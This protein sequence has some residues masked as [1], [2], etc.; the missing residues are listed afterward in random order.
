MRERE[1]N[2]ILCGFA[3]TRSQ[4]NIFEYSIF[5]V[6]L[7][8]HKYVDEYNLNDIFCLCNSRYNTT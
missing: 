3:K 2:V 6:I 1:I 5:D 7:I 4:I 8:E